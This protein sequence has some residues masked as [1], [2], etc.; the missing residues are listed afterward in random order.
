MKTVDKLKYNI[1]DLTSRAIGLKYARGPSRVSSLCTSEL[2][3]CQIQ[4]Y[5]LPTYLLSPLV[6]YW[7]EMWIQVTWKVGIVRILKSQQIADLKSFLHD[8]ACREF[9]RLQTRI[10]K[11]ESKSFMIADF[12]C[13]AL[14]LC[15]N[16]SFKCRVRIAG[17]LTV[18]IWHICIVVKEWC[19]ESDKEK[20]SDCQQNP[21]M[22]FQK[23]ASLQ[24]VTSLVPLTGIQINY[25]LIP[26]QNCVVKRLTL[27]KKE[28]T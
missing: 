13:P 24:A 23:F 28:Y 4:F 10:L 22:C 3:F 26:I 20:L 2:P 19:N 11:E 12:D 15:L 6:L 14:K 21:L 8:V 5:L 27:F 7:D 16:P 18:S 17:A 9:W 1:S 25:P